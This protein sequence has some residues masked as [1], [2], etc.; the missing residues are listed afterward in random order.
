MDASSVSGSL[1][2]LLFTAAAARAALLPV[3]GRGGDA[4]RGAMDEGFR[5]EGV[6]KG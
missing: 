4:E 6:S 3:G 1:A 2:G 5:L